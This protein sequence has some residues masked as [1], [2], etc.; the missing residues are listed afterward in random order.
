MVI[1]L[2]ERLP[3]IK[4]YL[5]GPNPRIASAAEMIRTFTDADLG[6]PAT[7]PGRERWSRA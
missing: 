6:A 3:L 5:R 7:T 4:E 1:A 2:G